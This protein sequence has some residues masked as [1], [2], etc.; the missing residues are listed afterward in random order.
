MTGLVATTNPS[1]NMSQESGTP[2]QMDQWQ[3][4]IPPPQAWGRAGDSRGNERGFDYSFA[5]AVRG[6]Y[7]GFAFYRQKG[8]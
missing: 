4:T 3:I 6:K 5:T 7:Q 2:R 8:P 1:G